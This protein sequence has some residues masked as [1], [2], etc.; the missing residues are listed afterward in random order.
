[1]AV[2]DRLQSWANRADDLPLRHLPPDERVEVNERQH[3]A[4]LITKAIRT[5]SGLGMMVSGPTLGLVLL[6]AV[7]L[8]ADT[9][10]SPTR[11]RRRTIVLLVAV[12]SAALFLIGAH[13]SPTVRALVTAAILLWL[14]GDVMAWFYDRLIVTDRRLYRVHGVLTTRRP[15]VALQNITVVDLE[16]GPAGRWYGT[17]MFDTPAQRDSPLHRF[18]YVRDAGNVHVTILQLRAAASAKSP[19]PS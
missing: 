3:A 13:T 8:L 12:L 11:L 14:L 1:M 6:F 17:L 9:I 5:G 15:S 7:A 10:R 2:I 4:V 16:M 19:P 18:T